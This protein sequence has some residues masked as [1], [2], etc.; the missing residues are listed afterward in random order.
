MELLIITLILVLGAALYFKVTKPDDS[1]NVA[2]KSK[3]QTLQ[4]EEQHINETISKL[5]ND[6][7]GTRPV[8]LTPGEVEAYWNKDK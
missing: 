4:Q 3:K 2:L 1:E 7:S 8:D 5:E 6:L